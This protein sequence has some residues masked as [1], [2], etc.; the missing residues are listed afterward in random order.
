M[1]SI[2]GPDYVSIAG[3]A[4]GV[5]GS[6]VLAYSLDPALSMIRTHLAA[7]D[8]TV[9]ASVGRGDVPVFRGFDKQHDRSFEQVT[10][11][12]KTGALL[13]AAGF[14]AQVVAAVVW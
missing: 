6:L 10:R 3:A 13:L 5:A 8:T 4:L 1:P 7:I 11:R 9:E 12:V 14:V 2:T